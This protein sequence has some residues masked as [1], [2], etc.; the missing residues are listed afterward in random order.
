MTKTKRVTK[1]Q[2]G[3]MVYQKKFTMVRS[4]LYLGISLAIFLMGRIST[5]TN[6]NLL[7]IVAVLGCLP[8]SKSTVNAIMFLRAKECSEDLHRKIEPVVRELEGGYDFLLTSYSANFALSHVVIRGN[9][10][11]S[12]TEDPKCDVAKAQQHLEDLF[13]QNSFK[14]MTFKI[15][16]EPGKYVERLQQLQKLEKS[17]QEAEM[18]QLVGNISL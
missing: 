16:T 18:L 3:Y 12:I 9:N 11:C 4:I 2:Y 5:G 13:R 8:A 14:G 1:G 15:F 10:L 6:A 17:G 7:S